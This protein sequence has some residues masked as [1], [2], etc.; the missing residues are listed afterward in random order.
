[1]KRVRNLQLLAEDGVGVLKALSPP[2]CNGD[3]PG[4]E[5][6]NAEDEELGPKCIRY[7]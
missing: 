6:L 4:G 5:M 2:I 7:N 3:K 1:M